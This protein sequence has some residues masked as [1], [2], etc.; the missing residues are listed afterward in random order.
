MNLEVLAE[1][2][3]KA[4]N[5]AQQKELALAF[6]EYAM[7]KHAE[8][9]ETLKESYQLWRDGMHKFNESDQNSF[10]KSKIFV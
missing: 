1:V 2:K 9:F 5:E 7:N 3:P 10:S 6:Y 8:L 4:E